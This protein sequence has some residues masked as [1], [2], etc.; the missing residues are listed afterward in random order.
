MLEL[1]RPFSRYLQQKQLKSLKGSFSRAGEFSDS[2]KGSAGIFLFVHKEVQ[3]T[4][5]QVMRE[6]LVMCGNL[7]RPHAFPHSKT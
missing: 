6:S 1:L 3:K 7:P 2:P 4:G 5:K